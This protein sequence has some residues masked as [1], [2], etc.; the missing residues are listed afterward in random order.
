MK[1]M[2]KKYQDELGKIRDETESLASEKAKSVKLL[3][4]RNVEIS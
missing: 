3:E 2:E 1:E 4:E